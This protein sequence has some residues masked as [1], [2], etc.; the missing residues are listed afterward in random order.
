MLG[1]LGEW[2]SCPRSLEIMRGLRHETNNYNIK[3]TPALFVSENSENKTAWNK[4][5]II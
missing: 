4:E 3:H 1:A 5:V 2:K